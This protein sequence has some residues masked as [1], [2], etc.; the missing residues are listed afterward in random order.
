MRVCLEGKDMDFKMIEMEIKIS[1]RKTHL[2]FELVI[3][4]SFLLSCW[5]GNSDGQSRVYHLLD[6]SNPWKFIWSASSRFRST[7][8]LQRH[9]PNLKCLLVLG[10]ARTWG[11]LPFSSF[12]TFWFGFES[13]LSLDLFRQKVFFLDQLG[14]LVDPLRL[15]TIRVTR[16]HTICFNE[17]HRSW[18]SNTDQTHHL[19]FSLQKHLLHHAIISL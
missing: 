14:T 17:I 6:V 2:F 19:P 5:A 1:P 9:F 15:V 16:W 11:I 12:S 13:E 10:D 4:M 3:W 18:V 7:K 8:R